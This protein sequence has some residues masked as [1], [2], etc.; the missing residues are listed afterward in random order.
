ML[1]L[2]ILGAVLALVP[3]QT[4]DA[5]FAGIRVAEV[6][7]AG[8]G[9]ATSYQIRKRDP[10]SNHWSADHQAAGSVVAGDT[11]FSLGAAARGFVPRIEAV[12]RVNWAALDLVGWPDRSACSAPAPG[13]TT[14]AWRNAA[15]W[16]YAKRAL[17][18][19][20]LASR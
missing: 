5:Y 11:A 13:S 12:G 10:A 20:H 17:C 6:R 8:R 16:W 9:A 3:Q 4:F 15:P 1:A 18:R 19:M 7:I 14:P 2:P